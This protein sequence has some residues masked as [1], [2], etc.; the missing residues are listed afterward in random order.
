MVSR[1][2]CKLCFGNWKVTPVRARVVQTLNGLAFDDRYEAGSRNDPRQRKARFTKQFR[3]G[4]LPS[5]SHHE[6]VQV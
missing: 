5:S 3:F 4:P 2:P 6:H 1:L